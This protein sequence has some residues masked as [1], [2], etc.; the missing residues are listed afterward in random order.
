MSRTIED[1]KIEYGNLCVKAGHLQYQLYVLAKDLELVN[2]SL[3]DLNFEAAKI[4]ADTA[5]SETKLETANVG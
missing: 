5:P 4:Q 2:S 1:I 3:K